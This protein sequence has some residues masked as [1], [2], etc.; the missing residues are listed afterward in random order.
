MKDEMN[1]PKGKYTE[2]FTKVHDGVTYTMTE[3]T[4]IG[5]DFEIMNFQKE[6]SPG[7]KCPMTFEEM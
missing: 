3:T 2:T 6:Y 5:R 4:V 1:R 7:I